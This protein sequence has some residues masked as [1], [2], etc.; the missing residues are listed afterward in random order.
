MKS[1]PRHRVI[2]LKLCR[3]ENAKGNLIP[4]AHLAAMA[5]RFRK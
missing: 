2:F 4:A 1:G 3:T 5:N